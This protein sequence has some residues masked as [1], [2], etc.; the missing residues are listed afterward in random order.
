MK[1]F[2]YIIFLT[3]NILNNSAY[4]QDIKG[5]M[6]TI[7]ANTKLNELEKELQNKKDTIRSISFHFLSD[8][9]VNL[10]MNFEN[11]HI[12]LVTFLEVNLNKI[13]NFI[14]TYTNLKYLYISDSEISEIPIEIIK[15]KLL[16]EISVFSNKDI[17]IS[18]LVVLENLKAV[19]MP[20][21]KLTNF[22]NSLTKLKKLE[23][24]DF[25]FME[26]N[27]TISDWFLS[28]NN[29]QTLKTLKLA[30]LNYLKINQDTTF[31]NYNLTKLSLL[32]CTNESVNE[33]LKMNL[34]INIKILVIKSCNLKKLPEQINNLKLL[35][36]LD[37]SDNKIKKIPT[38]ILLNCNIKKIVAVN[39][40]IKKST[41]IKN[42]KNQEL[43]I[44]KP[45]LEVRPHFPH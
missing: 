35:E 34:C 22:P 15:L 7:T 32:N 29:I 43:I 2:F 16:E 9:I 11:K 44:K 33:I 39:T 14:F 45:P 26:D 30:G 42:C 18:N 36:L 20:I 10:L 27:K 17:D 8:S 1:H 19:Y 23:N 5:K 13:P 25:I 31:Q 40:K 6:I 21:Y 3:F 12:E 28:I 24:L 38:T 4:S 41:V 37:F